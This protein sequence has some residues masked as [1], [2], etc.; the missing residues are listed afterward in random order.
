[1]TIQQILVNH[2]TLTIF[3]LKFLFR[4]F[5]LRY[6]LIAHLQVNFQQTCIKHIT[7]TEW[8]FEFH[9]QSHRL[10]LNS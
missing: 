4:S 1:M 6:E 7:R 9:F 10:L 2:T 3:T 5:P 8:T